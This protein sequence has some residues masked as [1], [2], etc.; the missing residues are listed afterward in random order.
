MSAGRFIGLVLLVAGCGEGAAVCGT[1]GGLC[2]ATAAATRTHW[3]FYPDGLVRADVD[4]D[5]VADLAGRAETGL[6]AS[7][8]SV[9]GRAGTGVSASVVSV[10]G[11]AETG[12]SASV[13][14]SPGP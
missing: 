12:L 7:V 6:S 5:G 3:G 8:V 1:A 2:L 11:R 4:G 9:V 14:C 13:V 10:V